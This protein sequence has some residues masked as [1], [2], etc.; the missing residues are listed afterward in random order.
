MVILINEM[1]KLL[2]PSAAVLAIA[3]IG[4]F[5]KYNDEKRAIPKG[6]SLHRSCIIVVLWNYWLIVNYEW[7]SNVI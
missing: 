6:T 3:G 4:M 1:F 7:M 2:Q 5:I